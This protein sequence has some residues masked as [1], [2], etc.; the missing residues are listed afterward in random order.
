MTD[1]NFKIN[2][3]VSLDPEV[4]IFVKKRAEETGLTVDE[5]INDIIS[6][7]AMKRFENTRYIPNNPN[8]ATRWVPFT[9]TI[10]S[11]NTIGSSSSKSIN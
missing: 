4:L 6:N 1:D 3:K 10:T 7:E 11:W 5:I 8:G 2:L 9:P